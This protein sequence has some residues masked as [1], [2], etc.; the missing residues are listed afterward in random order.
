M[1]SVA[2][3]TLVVHSAATNVFNSFNNIRIYTRVEELPNSCARGGWIYTRKQR[4]LYIHLCIRRTDAEDVTRCAVQRYT[5]IAFSAR[6]NLGGRDDVDR[7]ELNP[8]FR[9]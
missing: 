4:T 7:T 6:S 9:V 5:Y 3:A 1:Y 2:R 8:R